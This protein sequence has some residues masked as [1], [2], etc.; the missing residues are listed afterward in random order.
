MTVGGSRIEGLPA[1]AKSAA[2]FYSERCFLDQA[3]LGRLLELYEHTEGKEESALAR[4]VNE[5]LGLDQLDALRTG[6]HDALDFRRLKNLSEPLDAAD[7]AA[8]EAERSVQEAT[9]RLRAARTDLKQAR[10]ALVEV[11]Q[12]LGV[13]QPGRSDDELVAGAGELADGIDADHRIADLESTVEELTALQ[14][15]IAALAERP[16][17][18]ELEVAEGALAA[19]S[20]ELAAWTEQNHEAIQRWRSKADAIGLS[21]SEDLP[22]LIEEARA[23][24]GQRLRRQ[25]ELIAEVED[26]EAK[27]AQASAELADA[28][29]ELADARHQAGS[30]AEGLAALREHGADNICPVCDRDFR[31]V[32]A[33]HLRSHIDQKITE[34]TAEGDRLRE[35]RALHD[36]LAEET[37]RLARLLDERRDRLLDPAQVDDIYAR[38]DTLGELSS[39]Y[40]ELEPKIAAGSVLGGEV[41]R[42][43]SDVEETR[44][45]TDAATLIRSTLQAIA[46]RLGE[47]EPDQHQEGE[48]VRVRLMDL[49]TARLGEHRGRRQAQ[50]ALRQGAQRVA[51][52]RDE[53]ARLTEAVAEA[54]ELQK[55]WN[56]RIAEARRRQAVAREVH[57]AASEARS[58]IVQRVF[59]E[60]LNDVWQ[61]VFTRLAPREPFVPAFGIPT[62]SKTALEVK[63]ETVHTSGAVGGS[64][65][66]MLSAGNLN[67]AALSLFIA[68]HLAVEPTVPCLVFDDPVQSMDEV[69]ISQ[70]AAL[71]RLLSKR[72][73]RQLII[74]VH[75]R[76]LFDYLALELSPAYEGDELL[77]IELGS[78]T[79]GDDDGVRR[80]TWARDAAIAV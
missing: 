41:V 66:M 52:S 51:G 21:A 79:R 55:T 28:E 57:S 59:T 75:E 56:D 63:L 32:S 12:G 22:S 31:E 25:D 6:L 14:G 49:A 58:T 60:S 29:Q 1:M 62:S 42:A 67:T 33:T 20:A 70:F 24:L 23:S 48:A 61:S 19:A 7:D 78:R 8:K 38:L 54:A 26:L 77:T 27:S 50:A 74:A 40:V 71:M 3:S 39:E 4:F 46:A 47:P 17:T 5:I 53:V 65:Q 13:D 18:L 76:A 35:L 68:L 9:A 44:A 11:L 69:H 73:G 64:P 80:L 36:S 16:S 43:Q 2:Q 72:H 34:L 15:R 45:D 10:E 30:L 37:R